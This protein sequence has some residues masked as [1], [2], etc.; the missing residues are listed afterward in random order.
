MVKLPLL[1]SAPFPRPNLHSNAICTFKMPPGS[2]FLQIWSDAKMRNTFLSYVPRDELQ[3]FRLVCK[4]FAFRT[5]PA[6]FKEKKVTFRK[7]LFTSPSWLAM[8]DRLGHHVKTFHFNL[9]HM[10]NASLPPLIDDSGEAVDFVYE[11]YTGSTKKQYDFVPPYGTPEL[12]DLLTRHYPTIFHAAANVPSF[13]RVFASLTNVK[14]LKV[15]CPGQDRS[16]AY[17]RSA[18]DYALI[19]LRIA[20]ERNKLV[21]L[22]TLSL[23]SVHPMAPF[24]LNPFSGFG[25]LPN[26]ARR[27]RQVRNLV[28]HMDTPPTCTPADHLKFLHSY[29]CL[30][31]SRLKDFHFRWQ[32]LNAPWPLSLHNEHVPQNQRAAAVYTKQTRLDIAPL[33]M[34]NL[35]SSYAENITVD[36]SQIS[37]FVED[38]HHMTRRH[39][40]C[41]MDFQRSQLRSGTWDEALAPFGRISGADRW[42]K[43][44]ER[45]RKE[46]LERLRKFNRPS[47]TRSGP[48]AS[49]ELL[50]PVCFDPRS[51]RVAKH[52]NKHSSNSLS[53]K[54]KDLTKELLFGTEAK[55]RTKELLHGTEDRVKDLFRASIFSCWGGKSR[56]PSVASKARSPQMA[57]L[58][59]RQD[60]FH[61]L[62]STKFE[63][64]AAAQE[65]HLLPS[66][67]YEGSIMGRASRCA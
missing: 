6:L 4:D 65:M 23:L 24:Y 27:W 64:Y 28:I 17:M 3:S 22:D 51:E 41:S 29:L 15:S 14:H 52:A 16:E 49:L 20:V 56:S 25:T 63:G 61:I 33:H 9:P 67:R 37:A 39:D 2:A 21:K 62:P 30:F 13:I 5:A 8:L 38:H 35:R 1:T 34:P 36:A 48:D 42:E 57:V 11:P 50:R 43:A 44:M 45:A 18:V 54:T 40:R 26:S 32:G 55:V 19:S 12:Y 46:S 7:G 10:K 60:E 31:A 66:T 58:G 53:T 47:L 59:G